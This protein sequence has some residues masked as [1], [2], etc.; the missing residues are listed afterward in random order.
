MASIPQPQPQHILQLSEDQRKRFVASFDRVYSDIDGVLWS[1]EHNVPRAI[2]GYAALERAGKE[3]TFVT[4]N[5]V[6]TVDQ[7]IK[8]FGRLGMKVAP[9][10][11]WHPAQTTVHYL[12]SIKFEGLIYIIATKEFKD[13]LRAAGF[14]LLDGPN[15]FIEENYESL[16]KHIFD[17]QPVSAV[18]ID[19]DF[20]LSSAKLMRA[21]L[22]LRRPECILIAGATDRILPVA[23]GVNIIGPGMFSSILIESSGREAIT[24]GKP[25]RDLGD[26]LMKHHRITVPSRVLMIGDML[27]Q[28]VC[29]GRRCGFQ[30]LLVLSG[31]CT[32][33]QL[34]SEKL[35]EL[36]PDYYADSVADLV[37][38]F[39][40][41]TIKSH[42]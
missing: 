33:E 11:I 35:P 16:A 17:R 5:S 4:N 7:C 42:V 18:I 22:Y 34:Q 2:E 31:G 26:M 8:R 1:M 37:Q 20:N 10:Q 3:V 38:L 24:M 21:H 36:L 32:L 14:K 13:I 12:R 27:A 29:F 40:G 30:T 28:D 41:E 39:D 23:K 15:E 19:V 25:G 9:E 6:R